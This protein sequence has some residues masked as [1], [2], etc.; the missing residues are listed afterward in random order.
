V[1]ITRLLPWVSQT[2]SRPILT[3]Y[4]NLKKK[5]HKYLNK[6]RFKRKMIKHK[7]LKS[8]KNKKASKKKNHRK[9]KK[10]LQKRKRNQ[11]KKKRNSST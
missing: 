11:P 7:R 5:L 2:K 9:K 3:L 10:N 1:K 8:F 6:S 4:N